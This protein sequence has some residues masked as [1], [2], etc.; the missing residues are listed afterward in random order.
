MSHVNEAEIIIEEEVEKTAEPL[1]LLFKCDQCDYTNETEK[2]L[3]QHKRMK[4]RIFQTNG[5]DDFTE[6][7]VINEVQN[8]E[9]LCEKCS[10]IF[11]TNDHLRWHIKSKHSLGP[12]CYYHAHHAHHALPHENCK[13]E[14]EECSLLN[15]NMA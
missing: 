14:P 15:L 1:G 10:I 9:L 3:S 11:N 5:M 2:G 13:E 8:E 4:H 12:K 7:E 6:K